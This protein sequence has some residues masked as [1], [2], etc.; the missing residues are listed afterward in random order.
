MD[1]YF[2]KHFVTPLEDRQNPFPPKKNPFLVLASYS[3]Y[4]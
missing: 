2:V 4:I 3:T 1:E